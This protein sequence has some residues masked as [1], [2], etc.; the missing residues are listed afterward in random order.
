LALGLR[1]NA[2]FLI[3]PPELATGYQSA[4]GLVE[5]V[6]KSPVA[7]PGVDHVVA[8]RLGRTDQ[9]EAGIPV[10]VEPGR[11][12]ILEGCVELTVLHGGH[13]VGRAR[14]LDYTDVGPSFLGRERVGRGPGQ[15]ADRPAPATASRSFEVVPPAQ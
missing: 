7:I 10:A 6:T 13:G 5:R 2:V 14:E 3:S 4:Q 12:N 15:D 11:R 9:L 8:V 1:P